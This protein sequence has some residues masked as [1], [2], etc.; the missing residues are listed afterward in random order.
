MDRK[1]L[2]DALRRSSHEIRC[3]DRSALAAVYGAVAETPWVDGC[4]V[5][6]PSLRLVLRIAE[7]G[8]RPADATERWLLQVERMARGA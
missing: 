6:L 4:D 1:T 3:A 5:D 8:R 2:T 7:R